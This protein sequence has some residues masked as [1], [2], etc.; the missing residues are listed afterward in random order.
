MKPIE[1]LNML[2][3]FREVIA[4][5][6]FDNQTKYRLG[7][8]ILESLPPRNLYVTAAHTL[9]AV[10]SAMKAELATLEKEIGCNAS[11]QSGLSGS[12]EPAEATGKEKGDHRPRKK[13]LR[14]DA[15]H[16]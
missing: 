6:V 16:P 5:S 2:R 15:A 12:L 1:I 3:V 10:E 14:K 9:E 7:T 11:R 4:D 13:P 8:E